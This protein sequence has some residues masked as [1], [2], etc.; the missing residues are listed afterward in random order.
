MEK[1][2]IM[3][4]F[5]GIGG[6]ELGILNA[7]GDRA[8][9]VGYSEI[10][11]SACAVYKYHFPDHINYGD[12]TRIN[13]I[14]LPDFD[15]FVGGFPCQS[16]SFAGQRKGFEDT[17]GTLFFEVA[18]I[19]KVKRPKVVL[20]ENVKGLLYHDKGNTFLTIIRALDDLGYDVQWCVHNSKR[21]GVPQN[22]NRVY[23]E[24][25]LRG[26]SRP[27]IYDSLVKLQEADEQDR[28]RFCASTLTASNAGDWAKTGS[29]IVAISSQCPREVGWHTDVCP[30]ILA[31][32]GSHGMPNLVL[33]NTQLRTLT[34]TECERL[35]GFKDGW[36]AQGVYKKGDMVWT[37]EIKI[38]KVGQRAP[39]MV[40]AKGDELHP[41]LDS[42]RYFLAGNAVTTNVVS[43]LI[44]HIYG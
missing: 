39:H 38:N 7:I 18:R 2:R 8:E 21:H 44:K 40:F 26:E 33:E 41:I 29:N 30:T 15:L 36:T 11:P 42:E 35:Q 24:G 4:G 5:T 20:L 12:I 22:R 32:N 19:I 43:Y 34:P 28:Q 6:F 37:G 13:P 17:R 16:F 31:N 10:L 3:S 25:H 14:K 23:I 9:F 27:K 1:I